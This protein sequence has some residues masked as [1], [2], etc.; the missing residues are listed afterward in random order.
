[1]QIFFSGI[2]TKG[3][4]KGNTFGFPTINIKLINNELC[5]ETGIYAVV[6]TI[7]NKAIKG[8]LYA[9]T[10]PTLDMQ[11]TTIEIHL[12]DFEENIYNQQISFQILQKIREEI[13]F[14]NIEHLIE[15]L[16]QDKKMVYGFFQTL[17]P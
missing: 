5:V 4:G 3:L 15:Q 1:M 13:K 8:M 10:R 16:H 7:H 11:E 9:G 14:E 2:V 6:V 12:L 17:N